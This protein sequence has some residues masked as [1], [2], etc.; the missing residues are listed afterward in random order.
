MKTKVG[1]VPNP[2]CETKIT[3]TKIQHVRIK[4]PTRLYYKEKQTKQGYDK[5]TYSKSML[6]T[7][8]VMGD[9]TFIYTY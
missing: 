5:K 3:I 6:N 9:S 8:K 4:N 7:L 1:L 2:N